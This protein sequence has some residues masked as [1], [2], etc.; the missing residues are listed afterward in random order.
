[1]AQLDSHGIGDPESALAALCEC[2]PQ[3]VNVTTFLRDRALVASDAERFA[4][5]LGL[6]CIVL[7]RSCFALSSA[8]WLKLECGV[9][10]ILTGFHAGNRR[11]ARLFPIGTPAACSVMAKRPKGA[12]R[13]EAHAFSTNRS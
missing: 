13:R 2:A 5:R 6:H 10:A 9:I 12:R 11:G 3:Y 8:R 1:M 4:A 7:Q